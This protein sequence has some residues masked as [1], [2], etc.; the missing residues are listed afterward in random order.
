VLKDRDILYAKI[1]ELIASYSEQR[2]RQLLAN[3]P[4]A[5]RP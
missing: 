2:C 3:T 1:K 4:L 5:G